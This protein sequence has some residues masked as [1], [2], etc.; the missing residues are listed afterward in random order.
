[1]TAV[2]DAA[3]V[4]GGRDSPVGPAE[5]AANSIAPSTIRP[6]LIPTS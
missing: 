3:V 4:E 5:H 1:V 6:L 2:I